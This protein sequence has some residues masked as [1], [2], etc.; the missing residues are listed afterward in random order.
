MKKLRVLCTGGSGLLGTE[1]QRITHGKGWSFPSHQGLDVNAIDTIW[2]DF[3]FDLIVHA[4]AYTDVAK[5][6]VDQDECYK[7][8][9]QG[10]SMLSW[11]FEKVPFVYISS[12]YANNPVNYYSMTKREAEKLIEKRPSPYLIIRT[13]FKPRPYPYPTAFTDQYIQGDYVDVIAPLIVKSI[14][15]WNRRTCM[16]EYVGTGRKTVYELAKQTRPDVRQAKVSSVISVRL[17]KDYI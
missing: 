12:E 8:N 9:V 7:V 2:K 16:T 1:L 6:E 14:E 4:A 15:G 13:L 5:A 17:P 11:Y 10:T 3:T